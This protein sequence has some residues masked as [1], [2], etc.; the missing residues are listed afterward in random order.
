ME[1][2]VNPGEG[3]FVKKENPSIGF[4]GIPLGLDRI[5]NREWREESV[6][7]CK[8]SSE[9]EAL[10]KIYDSLEKVKLRII[11]REGSVRTWLKAGGLKKI[12]DKTGKE[13]WLSKADA[14]DIEKFCLYKFLSYGWKLPE[15]Y[16]NWGD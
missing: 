1:N 9:L 12:L 6:S 13:I 3:Y 14:K 7:N 15:D 5:R 8:N 2:Y 16:E 10:K 4:C 11:D